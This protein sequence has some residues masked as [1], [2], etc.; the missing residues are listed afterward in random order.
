MDKSDAD[1][2][3]SLSDAGLCLSLER[4][5]ARAE[6]IARA[7][8]TRAGIQEIFDDAAHW[9]SR[10]VPWKGSPIDPDPDGQLRRIVEGIDK[11]LANERA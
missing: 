6:L 10:N 4:D 5:A 11:M 7:K 3:A 2:G 8:A 9:N 1:S